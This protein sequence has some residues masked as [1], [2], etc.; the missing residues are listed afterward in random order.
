MMSSITIVIIGF[1]LFAFDYAFFEPAND[2]RLFALFKL[3][4][5]LALRAMEN[6][7]M[8]EEEEYIYLNRILSNE[9]AM[10]KRK[11]PIIDMIRILMHVDESDKERC[12]DLLVRIESNS[13]YS[14]IIR[15]SDKIF[16]KFYNI[17][18]KAIVTLFFYPLMKLLD[19]ILKLINRENAT[20]ANKKRQKKRIYRIRNFSENIPD[21]FQ[22]YSRYGA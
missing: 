19:L 9:I 3:R 7:E 14:D 10:I 15:E 5:E 8:Q 13:A 18:I 16:S 6:P 20:S 12:D 2:K 11:I 4:D 21:V 22:N 1:L 17:R